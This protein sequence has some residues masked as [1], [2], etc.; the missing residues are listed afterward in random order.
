MKKLLSTASAGVI[1]SMSASLASAEGAYQA[2]DMM[3]RFGVATVVPDTKTGELSINGL[4]LGGSDWLDVDPGTA[5]GFSFTYMFMPILGIEIL[6]SSPFEHDIDFDGEEL[7]STKHLPP[8]VSV[9]YYPI[10]NK[11]YRWQPYLGLGLNYTVFFD[12]DL[13]DADGAELSLDN[14]FGLAA[15]I[16]LDWLISDHW[17]AN[18]SAMWIDLNTEAS[19][20]DDGLSVTVK[21]VELDPWVY[22]INAGYRF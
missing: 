19:V 20:K 14:S 21:D 10:G 11:D 7:G 15:S 9:Q 6:A 8:T 22:R 12:E 13:E 16:G 17:F 2:G 4:D 18:I 3:L 5:L 1:L